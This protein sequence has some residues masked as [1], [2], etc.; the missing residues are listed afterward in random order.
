MDTI[1]KEDERSVMGVILKRYKNMTLNPAIDEDDLI[2]E[3]YEA[4]LRAKE[5]WIPGEGKVFHHYASMC[6]R[7]AVWRFVTR[8]ASSIQTP[9]TAGKPEVKKVL[10]Y[11]KQTDQDEEDIFNVFAE[12]FSERDQYNLLDFDEDFLLNALDTDL[13]REILSKI[14]QDYDPRD[15]ANERQRSYSSIF[16]QITKIRKR[17]GEVLCGM[18]YDDLVPDKYKP[19]EVIK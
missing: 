7:G 12:Y 8:N 17:L 16:N 19:Y 18:G 10:S 1:S 2:Q 15:I 14:L 3:G 5:R 4:L 9:T 11:N 13:Q 6:V